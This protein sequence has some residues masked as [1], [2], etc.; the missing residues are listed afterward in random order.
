MHDFEDFC[1][2]SLN[3]IMDPYLLAR[4]T[5]DQINSEEYLDVIADPSL[6]G[7]YDSKEMLQM[8][9]VAVACVSHS[10]TG[11]PRMGQVS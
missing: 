9:E 4:P 7:A 2:V 11:R 5:I 10:P 3:I 6:N 8:V 1:L